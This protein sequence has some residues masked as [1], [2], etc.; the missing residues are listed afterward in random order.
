MDWVNLFIYYNPNNYLENSREIILCFVIYAFYIQYQNYYSNIYKKYQDE[1]ITIKNYVSTK[2]EDKATFKVFFEY[3]TIILSE[4]TIW[5]IFILI[6]TCIMLV[7]NNIMLGLELSIIFLIFYMFLNKVSFEILTFYVWVLITFAGIVTLIVYIYQ[8]TQLDIIRDWYIPTIENQLPHILSTNLRLIGLRLF[9][10]NFESSLLAYYG[11]NLLSM[12]LLWEIQRL[13]KIT[14]KSQLG[15]I[16]QQ[17]YQELDAYLR[18]EE[19]PDLPG[20]KLNVH[21]ASISNLDL[22]QKLVNIREKVSYTK[23][24]FY[25]VLVFFCKSYFLAIFFSLCAIFVSYQVSVSLMVYIVAFS[26][27]FIYIFTKQVKISYSYLRKKTSFS[28]SKTIRLFIVERPKHNENTEKA[29]QISF[30]FLLC[31]GIFSIIL[32]YFYNIFESMQK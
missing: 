1:S 20:N 15:I 2:F 4:L 21:S 16:Q 5:T 29:R 27:S 32:S 31:N 17:E 6:F 19:S 22:T 30:K 14:T 3:S 23:Y 12:L 13:C 26:I 25:H 18:E 10:D 8:F 24:Y 28:I 11:I 9:Y 7:S